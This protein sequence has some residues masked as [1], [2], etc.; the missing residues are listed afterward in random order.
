MAV[1]QHVLAYLHL[2]IIIFLNT[3]LKKNNSIE[4]NLHATCLNDEQ[5]GTKESAIS[6]LVSL[7]HICHKR[8]L[9]FS[10]IK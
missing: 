2:I 7:K 10:K 3:Y 6:L 4:I 1:S 9:K 5:L 8:V